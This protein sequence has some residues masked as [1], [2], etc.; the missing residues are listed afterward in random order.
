LILRLFSLPYSKA[1]L[2]KMHFK[3]LCKILFLSTIIGS[4]YCQIQQIPQEQLS[5]GINGAVP[6]IGS[7]QVANNQRLID[8]IT[9]AYKG[10]QLPIDRIN[11]RSVISMNSQNKADTFDLLRYISQGDLSQ[12]PYVIAGQSIHVDY[13]TS[14]ATITGDLQGPIIGNIVLKKNENAFDLL[15]LYTFNNTADTA[16]ILIESVDGTSQEMSLGS[17]KG[18]I[19]KH[20]DAITVFP[21]KERK[22]V[23]RVLVSGEVQKPGYYSIVYGRSMALEYLKKSGGTTDIGDLSR[24]WV[25]RKGKS[26]NLPINAMTQGSLSV[27]P[28]IKFGLGNAIASGDFQIIPLRYGD[29][30]LE[31]GDELVVPRKEERVYISGLVKKPGAYVVIEGKKVE[32]YIEM[33]GGYTSEADPDGLRVLENFGQAYRPVVETVIPA[34]SLIIVPE[35]DKDRTTRMNLSIVGTILQ[36][37][38]SAVTVAGFLYTINK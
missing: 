20:L 26:K 7:V 22:D 33:A 17:L 38:T 24:T 15:S 11:L 1:L 37:L 34:G 21:I 23:F 35:K 31:D 32:D 4:A 29:I 28:E 6:S 13:A 2:I 10:N 16:H 9:I 19:P 8:V 14:W 3:T 18:Y 5:V 27:K 30:K 36:V 12:N 25:L